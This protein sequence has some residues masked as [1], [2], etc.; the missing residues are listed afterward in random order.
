M[1]TLEFR[2]PYYNGSV[3]LLDYMGGD[4][5]V[6]NAARVSYKAFSPTL[7]DKDISLI[8]YLARN[9]HMSPFRHVQVTLLLEDICEVVLRQ[10]YKHQVG[11]AY[12]AGDAR[13]IPTVWNEVSGRYV[14]F[15]YSFYTPE[16]FRPQSASSKQASDPDGV[17]EDEQDARDYYDMAIHDAYCAYLRLLEMGVCKEQARLVLP[18]AFQTSVVWTASLEALAH[19]VK[20]RDHP[21]AQVE[22]RKLAEIVKDVIMSIAPHATEALLSQDP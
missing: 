1:A 3:T 19:F 9:K 5:T 8:N 11:I 20:L 6:V 12:T 10:L 13:E 16:T 2:R 14:E 18:L 21:H 17:V 15:D 4:L 22:I 7:T